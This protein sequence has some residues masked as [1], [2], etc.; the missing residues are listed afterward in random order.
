MRIEKTAGDTLYFVIEK[1]NGAKVP[2]WAKSEGDAWEKF[3]KLL[4][5]SD[6]DKQF[7]FIES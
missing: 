4:G 7:F 6:E 5:L 1:S 3:A 2:I